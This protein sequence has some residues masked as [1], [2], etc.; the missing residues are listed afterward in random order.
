MRQGRTTPAPADV[1]E[2]RRRVAVARSGI[3]VGENLRGATVARTGVGKLGRRA[4]VACA[5]S[6]EVRRR[7]TRDDKSEVA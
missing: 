1:D 3:S 5:G 6:G 4:A 2:N 7:A